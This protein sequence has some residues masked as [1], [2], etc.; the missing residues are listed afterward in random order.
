MTGVQTCALPISVPESTLIA[1]PDELLLIVRTHLVYQTAFYGC[2]GLFKVFRADPRSLEAG[3][4]EVAGGDLGDRAVFVDHLRGF[5]VEANGVNGVRR[6][7]VYV[8]SSHEV[9]ND[10]YGWDVW[11]RHTVSILDLADLTTQ[12]L[13]DGNLLNCMCPRFW[14]WP[15]WSMPNLH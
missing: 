15:S 4:S 12:N 1:S 3:W 14:Q 7:C 5:T 10:D 8:A 2:E 9:V 6:N 11:G 13:S